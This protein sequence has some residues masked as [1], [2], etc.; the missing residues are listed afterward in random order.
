[1]DFAADIGLMMVCQQTVM[2]QFCGC[3]VKVCVCGGTGYNDYNKVESVLNKL[4]EEVGKD[5]LFI[6][7]GEAPGADKMGAFWAKYHLKPEQYKGFPANWDKFGKA[8]GP[9]RNGEMVKYGFDKLIA[10]PGNKG[11]A[12]MIKQTKEA[13]IPVEII[14]G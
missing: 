11:T 2:Q 14:D 12:N 4:A 7:T 13:G 3:M 5:N 9:I 1:M 8:A 6:I 10:F